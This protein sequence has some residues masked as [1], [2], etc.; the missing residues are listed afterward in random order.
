MANPANQQIS[1]KLTKWHFLTHTRNLKIFGPNGFI[2]PAMKSAFKW[3]SPKYVSG[4]VQVLIQVDKSG[5]MGLFQKVLITF[6]KIFL[7]WVP[8]S[9]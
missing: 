4:I 7:L 9:F 3:I 8:M 6:E 1:E 5:Q 2:W